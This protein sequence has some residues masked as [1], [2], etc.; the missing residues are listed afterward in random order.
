VNS[1]IEREKKTIFHDSRG[2][3]SDVGNTRSCPSKMVFNKKYLAKGRHGTVMPT[4]NSPCVPN[5]SGLYINLI[6]GVARLP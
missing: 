2:Y 4:H 3:R 1:V 5:L 6:L